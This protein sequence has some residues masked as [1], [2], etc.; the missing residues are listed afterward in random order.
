M[1]KN[2]VDKLSR[3]AERNFFNINILIARI[4]E[5]LLNPENYDI[6][7]DDTNLL[8]N[9]SNEVLSLLETMKSTLIYRVLET[10]YNSFLNYLNSHDKLNAEQKATIEELLQ[11]NIARNSSLVYQTVNYYNDSSMKLKKKFYL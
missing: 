1:N 11:S 10:R 4:Y 7:S 5:A 6:L 9:F 8:I 3:I 2:I